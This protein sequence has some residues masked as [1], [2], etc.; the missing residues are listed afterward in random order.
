M[1]SATREFTRTLAEEAGRRL[2]FSAVFLGI[3]ADRIL[4]ILLA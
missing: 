1:K 4:D 3:L 2:A